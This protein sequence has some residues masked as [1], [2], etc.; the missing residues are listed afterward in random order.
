[1]E[2][3]RSGKGTAD[4][5]RRLCK[6]ILSINFNSAEIKQLKATAS[7]MHLETYYLIE[8]DFHKVIQLADDHLSSFPTINRERELALFYKGKSLFYLGN[9]NQAKESFLTIITENLPIDNQFKNRDTKSNARY[10]LARCYY[11]LNNKEEA[12]NHIIYLLNHPSKDELCI[13]ET[14]RWFYNNFL[15]K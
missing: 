6:K 10:W 5:C 15:S 14:A 13:N 3:A 4:E 11:E 12:I 7:L 9:Y 1:M 8:K 2:L